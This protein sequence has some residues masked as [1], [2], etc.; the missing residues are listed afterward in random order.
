[1][2]WIDVTC[3]LA[4]LFYIVKKVQL[5]LLQEVTDLCNLTETF[6]KVKAFCIMLLVF[7][8]ELGFREKIM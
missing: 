2:G 6:I 7:I 1:M 5:L 4:S 8:N 3:V